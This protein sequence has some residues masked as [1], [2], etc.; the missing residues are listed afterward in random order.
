[1]LTVSQKENVLVALVKD[2]ND[3]VILHE[4]HWYRIPIESA[5]TIVR[6]QDVQ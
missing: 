1:M 3:H 5:P 6:K 4:K 2:K